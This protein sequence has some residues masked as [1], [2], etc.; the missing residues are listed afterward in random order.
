MALITKPVKIGAGTW[1]TSRSMLLGGT[2][3]GANCLVTPM[4]V[5]KAEY[6]DNTLVSGNP[7]KAAGHRFP[8]GNAE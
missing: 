2:V 8:L 3:L 7:S 4:S 5:V 1:I 6:A